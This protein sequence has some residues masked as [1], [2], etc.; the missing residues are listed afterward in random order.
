MDIG[1][2]IRKIRKENDLSQEQFA[3]RFHVTRQTVSN[4]ENNKNYPDMGTLKQISD[5]FQISFDTLLKDDIEWMESIDQTKKKAIER[6]RVIIILIVLWCLA[7]MFLFW[8]LSDAF[9]ATKNGERINTSTNVRMLVNL[10]DSEPS[11]AITYT[12][13]VDDD[14]ERY[15][16]KLNKLRKLV[17]G[18]IEGDI[19]AVFT[20]E[21]SEVTLYFQDVIYQNVRP[22]KIISVKAELENV[23]S[24]DEYE[25]ILNYSFEN[26]KIRFHFAPDFVV[27]SKDEI[28]WYNCVII[29]EYMMDSK[30][31]N[32]ITAFTV[33]EG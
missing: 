1:S 17:L 10:P 7:S 9:K 16:K 2:K 11:R 24:S 4:W 5:E 33:I 22:E 26:G 21:N 6:K 13:E 14:T 15:Q 18:R 29:V 28:D 23:V 31:Y 27:Y 30:K 25:K 12:L 32:S 20:N 3:Q 8:Y 19:P